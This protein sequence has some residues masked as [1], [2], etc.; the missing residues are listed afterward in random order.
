VTIA[1]FDGGM[2]DL[3]LSGKD[4]RTQV[5]QELGRWVDAFVPPKGTPEVSVPPAPEDKADVPAA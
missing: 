4:V 1:R 5:F 2:H 3:T